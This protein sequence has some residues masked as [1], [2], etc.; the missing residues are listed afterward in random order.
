MSITQMHKPR[1]LGAERRRRAT[2]QM[3][4]LYFEPN[5]LEMK[6]GVKLIYS[7]FVFDVVGIDYNYLQI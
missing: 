5:K 4:I 2:I 7:E 6:F 1:K 3:Y